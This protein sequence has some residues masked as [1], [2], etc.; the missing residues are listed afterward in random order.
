MTKGKEVV[1]EGHVC[2]VAG[3]E[4]RGRVGRGGSFLGF[5][6]LPFANEFL[7]V[8]VCVCVCVTEVGAWM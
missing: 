2:L 6:S 8:S 5:S 3:R 4:R 1:G 7:Q